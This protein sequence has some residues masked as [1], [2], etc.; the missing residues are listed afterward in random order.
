MRIDNSAYQLRA[1]GRRGIV[2]RLDG[3]AE[4]LIEARDF[5]NRG[6]ELPW[7]QV[8]FEQRQDGNRI[9]PQL[10]F[11]PRSHVATVTQM[12]E[13]GPE[14]LVTDSWATTACSS[15]VESTRRAGREINKIERASST[16]PASGISMTLASN[17][18]CR[19]WRSEPAA[20]WTVWLPRQ[21]SA[22]APPLKAGL[23]ELAAC[24]RN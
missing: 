11:L 5:A 24:R 20:P 17:T 14:V 2:A 3:R 21:G 1:L 23:R 4:P 6:Y 19:L 18:S 15:A 9:A 10:K 8:K 16:M 22:A 13:F 7:I 12:L